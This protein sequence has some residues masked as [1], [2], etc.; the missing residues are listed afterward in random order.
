MFYFEIIRCQEVGIYLSTNWN[1]LRKPR[2]KKPVDT[3]G[4]RRFGLPS[5][6]IVALDT[7]TVL[8]VWTNE[9]G[10]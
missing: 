1:S 10:K 7:G 6:A 8:A 3:I 9:I 2:R 5:A 4:S